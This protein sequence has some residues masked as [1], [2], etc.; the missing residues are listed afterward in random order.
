[1]SPISIRRHLPPNMAEDFGF[2]FV[3]AV[4]SH[5]ITDDY[6]LWELARSLKSQLHQQ[7]SLLSICATI[8]QQQT[9]ISTNPSPE[10]VQQVF[11]EAYGFDILV[12]NL[13]RLNIQQ[14]FGQLQL[15]AIYGPAVTTRSESH[16]MIGVATLGDTM[17]FTFTYFEPEMLPAEA[18]KFQQ[19]AMQQL[20]KALVLHSTF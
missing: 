12:R 7:I 15:V 14:Q 9:L 20:K 3:L 2:Y 4:T 5:A 19:D 18:V 1:M 10:F 16:R 17:F 6:N 13:T 8:P 11:S